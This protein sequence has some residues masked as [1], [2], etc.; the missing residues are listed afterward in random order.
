VPGNETYR[1]GSTTLATHSTKN[2]PTR[3]TR[4]R[5]GRRTGTNATTG[6]CNGT[7]RDH[8]RRTTGVGGRVDQNG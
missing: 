1:N 5:T 8:R 2:T 3:H 6:I 7:R 4:D